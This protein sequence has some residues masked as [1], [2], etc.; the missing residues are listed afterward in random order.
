MPGSKK[1]PGKRKKASK[2]AKAWD[3]RFQEPTDPLVE[4]FTNS[5]AIDLEMADQDIRGSVAHVHGLERAGL[6]TS[7]ETGKIVRGLGRV[8]KEIRDGKFRAHPSDEDVHMAVERRL[9]ELV[10]PVG[11]KVHTGR[12]RNDQVATDVRLWLRDQIDATIV[13]IAALQG[14]LLQRAQ[15]D[16]DVVVP[17]Y[18][19][20]QRAQPVLLS[21][22]WL[23]Y[24][25]MLERDCDRLADT[26]KRVNVL[27]LGAGALSGAGFRLNRRAV[28]RELAFDSVTEN[29]LDAVSDRDFI[30]EFLSA[31]SLI[32]MH[33]S[34]LSE[35]I[36]LWSS[37]E[38][39]FLKLPDAFATGS[40][41]M[42][43]KKNPDVAELV[44]GRT[45]RVYGSLVTILTTLKGLPLAY[46]RDLQ[47]D[48]PPLFDAARTTRACLAVL[49]KML[50]KLRVQKARMREAAGG[51]ALATEL[52]DYLVERGLPFREGH[53]VVGRIVGFCVENDRDL[54]TLTTAELQTFSPDFGDDARK[55]LRIET[56]LA[57]RSLVG[58]TARSN[59][60]R[61][62]GELETSV[63]GRRP[64]RARKRR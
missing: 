15:N 1:V 17:G 49:A 47:E 64:K 57:R 34:R 36:V 48:K 51:L 33:L 44:R 20:L 53:S 62:I 7:S 46:N 54:S 10:G 60:E 52:A 4:T 14:S 59:V 55:R 42:P 8:G 45:G 5:L 21:H 56:A 43:Q 18:T 23:A 19:H 11:G 39:G 38:F 58:G 27:P 16:L 29:S 50:P 40:S 41:M 35:E 3:G 26:R 61:R 12:S 32:A 9:T 2:V 22:H 25:E 37:D 6:L 24:A 63:A 28:A 31:A 13:D 30:V